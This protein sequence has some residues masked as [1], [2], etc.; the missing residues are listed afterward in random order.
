MRIR[1]ERSSEIDCTFNYFGPPDLYY[2]V[3]LELIFTTSIIMLAYLF[4][5]NL[6]SC[7]GWLYV[8]YFCAI[9]IASNR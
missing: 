1:F 9:H 8:L 4:L 7:F 3:H 5:Y 6:A 2:F